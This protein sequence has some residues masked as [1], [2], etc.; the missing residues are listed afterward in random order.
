MVKAHFAYLKVHIYRTCV[1]GYQWKDLRTKP[2]LL[3]LGVIGAIST[4]NE[5]L[6]PVFDSGFFSPSAAKYLNMALDEMLKKVRPLLISLVEAKAEPDIVNPSNIGNFHG[7]IYET[8]MEWAKD[9]SLNHLDIDGVPPQWELYI[10]PFL[11]EE[12]PI[13]DTAPISKL[14]R[15]AEEKEAK[16]RQAW[17]E[18]KAKI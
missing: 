2:I 10:K 15:I 5:C 13:K 12:P 4:L 17:L 6:G 16:E 8:Q 18:A 1:E 7:D 14:A 9:S 3:D 11:H